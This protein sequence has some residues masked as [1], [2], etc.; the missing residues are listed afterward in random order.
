[1]T[2]SVDDVS[3]ELVVVFVVVSTVPSG[4]LVVLTVVVV[5]TE[6]VSSKTVVSVIS[7]LSVVDFIVVTFPFVVEEDVRAGIVVVVVTYSDVVDPSEVIVV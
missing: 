5:L 6:V 2:V 4:V 7:S 1:M 3:G